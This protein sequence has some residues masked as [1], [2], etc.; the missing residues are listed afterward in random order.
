MI[1]YKIKCDHP[2]KAEFEGVFPSKVSFTEQR[3]KKMII[4]PMCDG[5]NLRFTKWPT[6]NTKPISQRLT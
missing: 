6:K 4:C 3:M 2:C 1:R 5:L